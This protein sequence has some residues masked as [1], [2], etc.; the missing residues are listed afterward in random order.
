MAWRGKADRLAEYLCKGVGSEIS[1][2][3]R[4]E[5]NSRL[6]PLYEMKKFTDELQILVNAARLMVW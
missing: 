1:K 6:P 2:L 3:L 4:D 5:L